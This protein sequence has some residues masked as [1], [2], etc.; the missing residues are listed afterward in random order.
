MDK[1]TGISSTTTLLTTLVPLREP[2]LLLL[3]TNSLL[4]LLMFKLLDSQ[5]MPTLPKMEIKFLNPTSLGNW[6]SSQ[7]TKLT[8]CS[9]KTTLNTSLTNWLLLLL[10]LLCIM[11][12]LELTLIQKMFILETLSFKH[13][14]PPAIGETS[15]CS[16]STRTWETTWLSI[17]N[18]PMLCQLSQAFWANAPIWNSR[19]KLWAW[20]AND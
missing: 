12:W 6:L 1:T 14:Q 16:S 10:E 11:S 19:R 3:L 20:S 7:L 17:Q 5:I 15:T 13:L 9:L 4:L 18:G 2:L 8:P